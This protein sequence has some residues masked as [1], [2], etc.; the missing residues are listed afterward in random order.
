MAIEI[1]KA[2]VERLQPPQYGRADATGGDSADL[3][4]F[5]MIGTRNAIRYV[6]AAFHDPLV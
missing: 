4:G 2:D 1:V 5:Q 3:H 6:P